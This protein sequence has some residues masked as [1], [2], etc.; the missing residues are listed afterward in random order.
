MKSPEQ[1]AHAVATSTRPG[2]PDRFFLG[3][4]PRSTDSVHTRP[5]SGSNRLFR[6][7]RRHRS[8]IMFGVLVVILCG[9]GV[10]VLGF[11]SRECQIPLIVSLG[12]L[13]FGTGGIRNPTLCAAT[14]CRPWAAVIHVAFL[15][16]FH[17][18]P[19]SRSIANIGS[20]ARWARAFPIRPTPRIGAEIR[21]AFPCAEPG[22]TKARRSWA[23]AA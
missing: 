20:T 10:A 2:D 14:D 1:A 13:R 9:D 16:F 4:T 5:R 6:F 8:E 19:S 7:V 12:I 21:A 3:H 23:E 15:V 17:R 11:S 18:Y 22:I